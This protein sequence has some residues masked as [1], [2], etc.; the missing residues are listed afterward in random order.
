MGALAPW[1]TQKYPNAAD[2]YTFL[3]TVALVPPADLPANSPY[4]TWALSYAEE[5]TLLV[6]RAVGQDFYCFAVY[7]LATSFLLNWCPD[8]P[9]QTFFTQTRADMKLTSFTPGVVNSAADQGTSDGLL[10]PEFLSGL[11]MANLQQLKDPFGRAWLA[12]NQETGF[13]WGIS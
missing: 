5:L 9:G 8:Q 10:S 6:L 2:L 12:A 3:T 7:C 13:L 1:Q 11:T 4:V